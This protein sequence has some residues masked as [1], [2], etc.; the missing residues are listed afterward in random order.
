MLQIEAKQK[1]PTPGS[2]PATPRSPVS[3]H[4]HSATEADG[5]DH[6]QGDDGACKFLLEINGKN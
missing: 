2:V 3:T 6:Q 4:C 1:M 5:I